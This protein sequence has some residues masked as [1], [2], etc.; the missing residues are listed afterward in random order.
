MTQTDQARPEVGGSVVAAGITTNYLHD[1]AADAPPVLLLHG[2]GPG[3]TAYANWRLTIPTLAT[4]LRVV[5]PDLV[6]FGFT[7]ED[8]AK[9]IAKVSSP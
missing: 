9:V 7:E 2:S 3:V 5:A 4:K 6:G 1:G 8:A